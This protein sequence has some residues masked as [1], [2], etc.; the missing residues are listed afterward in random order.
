MHTTKVFIATLLITLIVGVAIGVSFNKTSKNESPQDVSDI[1]GK[2]LEPELWTCSMHPQIKLPA[3]GKCPICGMDLI[4]LVVDK[5]VKSIKRKYA[6]SMMCTHPI[7]LPGKCPICGMEM[8][9]IEVSDD[10]YSIGT[11]ALSEDARKLAKVQTVPVRHLFVSNE[12]RMVGK[13]EFDETRLNY[14]TAWVPGRLDRLYVDYTGISIK[15][16]DHLVYLYSE[17]L[18]SAQQELLGS[19]KAVENL[20]DSSSE[21]ALSMA[22]STLRASQEKLRLWGLT[23]DQISELGKQEKPSDHITIYSPISGIVVHKN[24]NQGAYVKTGDRVYTIADLSKVWIKLDAY[25]SDLMWL[26]YGQKVNFSVEAYP[27]QKFNGAVSFIDPILNEST[28]T[29]KVRVNADN[30]DG[31]LKP[32]MFVRAVLYSKLA[33]GGKVMDAQLSGKWISPMHPEIIKEGPGNCDVC[34]MPL[35]KAETL[36]YASAEANEKNA[37][38]VVPVSAPLITGKRA[39]VYVEHPTEE[40]RY[41]GREIQL[42]PRAGNFYIV[43]GGLEENEKVVT[44]GNFKI[45]SAIQ[46]LGKPSM[47]NPSGGVPAASHDHD[48]GHAKKG[49]TTA[50]DMIIDKEFK[51][52]L[53]D[54]YTAYFSVQNALSKDDYDTAIIETKTAL[55]FVDNMDMGLLTGDVHIHWMTHSKALIHA[56]GQ[57]RDSKDIQSARE[58]FAPLSNVM[59][60]IVSMFGG[61]GESPIYKVHCPMAFNDQGADWLQ[62]NQTVAN[63]YFGSA[64]LNCGVVKETMYESGK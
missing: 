32:G 9:E 53:R 60:T 11:I 19:I 10:D 56:L 21:S 42:G 58:Y 7:D 6:C 2:E 52:Q 1:Q 18:L 63:P 33:S 34:G 17:E 15:K 27:G 43:L 49:Q 13:V 16:G 50:N 47:M 40:G 25:E 28:R 29:V 14:I 55:Q 51:R 3:S 45:D 30:A 31:L 24:L 23:E 57:L 48:A 12:I 35:V 62:N 38:L 54:V 37:P 8:V 44:N 5:E 64:M 26:R 36:G 4:P 61:D 41:E 22:K 59:I 46:I 39:V 20:F